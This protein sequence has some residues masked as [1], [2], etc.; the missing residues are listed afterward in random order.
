M[1][2]GLNDDLRD[3]GCYSDPKRSIFLW[4]SKCQGVVARKEAAKRGRVRP[5]WYKSHKSWPERLTALF[6]PSCFTLLERGQRGL[7]T[8]CNCNNAQLGWRAELTS[9]FIL[10]N[11]IRGNKKV[12]KF[13]VTE[14]GV[15]PSWKMD[16]NE[17]PALNYPVV[18][19]KKNQLFREI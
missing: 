7:V 1:Q 17:V 9:S 10:V 19:K 5:V 18:P 8:D 12:E 16:Q 13:I 14:A 11:A 4:F 6:L 3:T 2:S 15:A